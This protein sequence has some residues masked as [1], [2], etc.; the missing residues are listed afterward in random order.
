MNISHSVNAIRQPN[1]NDCWATASAMVL[2]LHGPNAVDEVK[3][4]ASA[5]RLFPNGSIRP[6]SVH[7]LARTLHLRFKDLTHPLQPL[8]T[9]ILTQ[10]LAGSCAAAFGSYNYP[11][12]PTSTQHVLLFYR[13]HGSDTD[14]MVYFIDPYTARSYN[15]LVSDI[16]EALGSVDYFIYS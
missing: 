7:T 12:V 8:S 6:E 14:P 1:L 11:G 16:N 15:Y 13:L 4:R 2:R 10:V 3:R 9:N 5:V